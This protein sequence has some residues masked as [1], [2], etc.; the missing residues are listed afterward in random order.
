[1]RLL[2]CLALAMALG[3]PSIG[4][5]QPGDDPPEVRR[6]RSLF[7]E[8]LAY[9]DNG[10]WDLAV[11]RFRAALD[12][13][14]SAN[15]RFNLAQSL[16]RMGRLVDALEELQ[17][18]DADPEVAE[19]LRAS[20]AQLRA[21]L[22]PR[23]GRLTVE[24]AGDASGT[25]V[26]IDSRPIE[27]SSTAVLTDPGVRITRLL[28]GMITLDVEE[29]AVPEGREARVILEVPRID[30]LGHGQP[31]ASRGDD[32]LIWGLVIGSIALAAVG[33]IVAVGV[34]L[35]T[36]APSNGDFGPPILEID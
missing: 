27:H 8:G 32:A 6:A 28:R 1:M 14:E 5:A 13:R 35:A 23:L 26:V 18:I 31:R 33:A 3:L 25:H 22:E 36:Q 24:V 11:Q 7:N 17:R 10:D 30:P 19:E 21:R 29:V 34:F 2:A 20:A 15:I 9:A 16:V 4:L 12:L